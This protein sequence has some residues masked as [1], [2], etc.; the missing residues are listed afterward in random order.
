VHFEPEL[1]TS[2]PAGR[3]GVLE[4]LRHNKAFAWD[5]CDIFICMARFLDIPTREVYG[6]LVGHGPHVW[7]RVYAPDS[8]L[9]VDVDPTFGWFG[10]SEEYIPLFVSD[11]GHPP[12]VFTKTPEIELVSE[13]VVE[14]P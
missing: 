9:W 13:Q 7:V 12:F 3:Y 14:D 1:D 8:D 5:K 6:W 4:A 11:I 2:Q 10:V